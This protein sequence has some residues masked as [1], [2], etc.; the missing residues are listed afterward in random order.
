MLL[1]PAAEKV[2]KERRLRARGAAEL[3]RLKFEQVQIISRSVLCNPLPLMNPP[4][5]RSCGAHLVRFIL[6]RLILK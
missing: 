6:E 3:D 2:T 5:L 4:L 1:S